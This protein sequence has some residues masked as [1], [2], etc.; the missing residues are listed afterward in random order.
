MSRRIQIHRI[1]YL[2][3][4]QKLIELARKRDSIKSGE[5]SRVIPIPSEKRSECCDDIAWDR[6]PTD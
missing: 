1:R 4:G 3:H 5:M 2:I 6:Y